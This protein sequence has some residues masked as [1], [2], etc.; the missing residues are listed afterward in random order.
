MTC[1]DDFQVRIRRPAEAVGPTGGMSNGNF[2]VLRRTESAGYKPTSAK[3][4]YPAI[5]VHVEPS[6]RE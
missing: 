2:R 1:C 5:R 6:R 4:S 3:D